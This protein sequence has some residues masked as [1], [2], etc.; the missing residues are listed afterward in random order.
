MKNINYLIIDFEG[1][2]LILIMLS[3]AFYYTKENNLILFQIIF[4]LKPQIFDNR[5]NIYV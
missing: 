5:P 3:R 2:F 1:Y 4:R